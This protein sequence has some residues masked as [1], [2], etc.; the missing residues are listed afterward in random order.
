MSSVN[1]VNG[2][3]NAD[4]EAS[5]TRND[6]KDKTGLTVDDFLYLLAAQMQNQ[7]MMNPMNDTEF[8]GQLAQFTSLQ[9]IS[10]LSALNATSYSVGL[11]GKEVT[12]ARILETGK[13]FTETGVVTGIGLYDGDPIIYI[14]ENAYS[15]SEI[16]AV[17]KIPTK[18]D[19]D[20]GGSTGGD[21]NNSGG[22]GE[23]GSAEG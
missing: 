23:A 3:Y 9:A 4:F 18:D 17:G 14:G 20:T 2:Y 6:A 12:V 7:D 13:L 11:L 19:S 10:D 21:D 8:I 16:M 15:L 1:S 5:A 22:T